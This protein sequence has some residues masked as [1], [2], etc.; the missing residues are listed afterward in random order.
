MVMR[1]RAIFSRYDWPSS[2]RRFSPIARADALAAARGGNSQKIAVHR[3]NC[4]ARTV[5]SRTETRL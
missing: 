4:E 5:R 1:V 2:G 3:S